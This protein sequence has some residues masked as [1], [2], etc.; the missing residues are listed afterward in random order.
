MRLALFQPDIPQNTGAMIRICACFG[1]GLDI[2]HPTGYIFNEKNIKQAALDYVESVSLTEHDSWELFLENNKDKRIILLST[3][4]KVNY[5]KF[6]F[7]KDDYLLVGR[8]SAGVPDKVFNSVHEVIT[9]PMSK[10]S[11]SLNVAVSA[12]IVIAESRRQFEK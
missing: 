3:K 4:G 9:I 11:R 12:G 8:E 2:I 6:D 5:T 1:V 10:N 7:K